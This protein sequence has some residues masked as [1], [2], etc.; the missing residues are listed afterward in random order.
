VGHVFV[1]AEPSWT[2][3]EVV[4][5]LADTGATYTVIPDDLARRI[6]VALSPRSLNVA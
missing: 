3:S 4:R 6:G 5:F 2:G 1:D